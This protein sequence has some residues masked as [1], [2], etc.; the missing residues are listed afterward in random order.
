MHSDLPGILHHHCEVLVR[1]NASR[2]ISEIIA[3]FF[4]GN[5]TVGDLRIPQRHELHVDLL[6]VLASDNIGVL[7]NIIDFSNIIELHS[8]VTIHIKLI[9][10]L[11]DESDARFIQVTLK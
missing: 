8:A 9:V 11:P 7:A 3:E 6:R 1:V 2:H 5:N 4:K 10:S